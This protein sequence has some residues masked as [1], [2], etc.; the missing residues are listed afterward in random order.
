[1]IQV[2]KQYLPLLTVP[3]E[4]GLEQFRSGWLKKVRHLRILCYSAD[5]ESP[6]MWAHYADNHRGVVLQ[7]E[8][9]D[10][11]D[12][13]SLLASPVMY[14]SEPPG[15]PLLDRW[16]RAFLEEEEIDWNEY[17][18]EYYYV[19]DEEWSYER[20]YRAITA[21][22]EDAELYHDSPFFPEDLRGV[23]L[24]T[25]I[26]AEQEEAIR[27]QLIRYPHISLFRATLNYKS[28]RVSYSPAT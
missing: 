18:H 21:S 7:F 1:M 24:G 9:S 8:S 12:S 14:R 27:Q 25:A 11:R 4:L 3:S 13:N 5:A 2:I 26:D 20:E 15:L 23:I 16:V 6:A 28:R 22:L 10:E 19:K 17:F